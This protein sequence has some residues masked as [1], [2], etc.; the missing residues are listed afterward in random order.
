MSRLKPPIKDTVE[1]E[2]LRIKN[3]H[4]VERWSRGLIVGKAATQIHTTARSSKRQADSRKFLT[5]GQYGGRQS[6]MTLR[7]LGHEPP[8]LERGAQLAPYGNPSKDV[9]AGA[10]I[11]ARTLAKQNPP[12]IIPTISSDQRLAM[13]TPEPREDFRQPTNSGSIPNYVREQLSKSSYQP[14]WY[15]TAH[16][17]DLQSSKFDPALPKNAKMDLRFYVAKGTANIPR[18]GR[19]PP[20]IPD[21]CFR[22][23]ELG[24]SLT[25]PWSLR[26][27]AT[28][29][30]E[31]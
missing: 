24:A 2:I 27:R 25:Q 14:S 12:S 29:D 4:G 17:L 11:T 5:S 15:S 20:S 28:K 6:D 30:S 10:Q 26:L 22:A 18:T 23:N 31:L 8:A 3:D 1:N 21:S 16:P 7:K 9:T 13:F 19:Y